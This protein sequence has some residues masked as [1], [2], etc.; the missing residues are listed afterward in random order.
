MHRLL[1]ADILAYYKLKQCLMKFRYKLV[2]FA[3]CN[4]ANMQ[5][6]IACMCTNAKDN[7]NIKLTIGEN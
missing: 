4:F 3:E 6:E 2:P 1:Q 5:A 7:S